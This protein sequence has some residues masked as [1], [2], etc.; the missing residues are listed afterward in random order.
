MTIRTRYTL[1]AIGLILLAGGAQAQ[2][3]NGDFGAGLAGWNPAGDVVASGGTLTLSTAFLSD[4]GDDAPFNLSGQD[5]VG[6]DALESA[7][8]LA[9]YALDLAGETAFEGSLAQQ[10]FSV[11]AGQTL[12]FDWSFSTRETLFQDHAFFVLDGR[13]ITLASLGTKPLGTQTFSQTYTLAGTSTLSFGVADTG[14]HLGVSTLSIQNV[15]ITAIP[16]PG[17]WALLLAGMLTGLLARGAFSR[18]SD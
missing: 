1:P 10:S 7:T 4:G 5:A 13:V 6:I 12:S 15:Q 8:G 2:L 3:A 11:A 9:P 14:D 17:Q 18:R 16:E